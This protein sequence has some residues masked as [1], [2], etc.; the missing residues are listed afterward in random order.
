MNNR[1][2]KVAKINNIE[3]LLQKHKLLISCNETGKKVQR[4]VS[5]RQFGTKGFW[6]YETAISTVKVLESMKKEGICSWS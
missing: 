1:Q 3:V 6:T 4:R 5:W 2:R